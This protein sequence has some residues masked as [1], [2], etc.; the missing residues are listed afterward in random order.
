MIVK[1]ISM[2]DVEI[3]VEKFEKQNKIAEYSAEG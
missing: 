1:L 3:Y 2:F